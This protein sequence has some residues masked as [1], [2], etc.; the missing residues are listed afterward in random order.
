MATSW[1][2]IPKTAANPN[3]LDKFTAATILRPWGAF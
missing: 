2:D 3:V 1:K